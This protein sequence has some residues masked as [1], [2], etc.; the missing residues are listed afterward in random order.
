MTRNEYLFTEGRE[1]S[2]KGRKRPLGRN[3]GRSSMKRLM[4]LLTAGAVLAG[5]FT[6]AAIADVKPV[7]DPEEI[8][9]VQPTPPS[10]PITGTPVPARLVSPQAFQL[11]WLS[12]NGGGAISASSPSYQL[13]LSVGQSVAGAASS[14][15]YQMGIGFWYGAAAG[16][17]VCAAAKGDMNGVGGIT[18]ADAVLMLN[19]V[20]LGS[21]T[22][23]VGGDCNLCYSDLN[24]LGGLT[25]AD[26]VIQ[27]NYVFLGTPLPC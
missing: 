7:Q 23:T 19:C 13:G 12:I 27:L 15:S 21:G 3:K 26:A 14:P 24:C 9:Q 1:T 2:G 10:E 25:P 18:P 6:T 17:P 22:G 5:V 20:F 8:I 16:A 4:I 11:N